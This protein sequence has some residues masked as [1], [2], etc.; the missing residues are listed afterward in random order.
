MMFVGGGALVYTDGYIYALRGDFTRDFW[1]YHIALNTWS[2][3]PSPPD[4]IEGGGALASGSIYALRG[5]EETDFWKFTLYPV[6]GYMMRINRLDI[7][8]SYLTLIGLIGIFSTILVNR[9][10]RKS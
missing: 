2:T 6:G 1:R 10:W 5:D 4:D 3:M 8:A 9:K 7:L